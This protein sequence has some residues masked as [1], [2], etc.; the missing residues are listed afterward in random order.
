MNSFTYI[1]ICELIT[2]GERFIIHAII[3]Y[4]KLPSPLLIDPLIFRTNCDYY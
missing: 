1:Y 3:A 4:K 2:L